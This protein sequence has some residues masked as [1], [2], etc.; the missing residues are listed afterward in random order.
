MIFKKTVSI[1]I[2]ISFSTGFLSAQSKLPQQRPS[3]MQQPSASSK[4]AP[5]DSYER[6]EYPDGDITEVTAVAGSG[7]LKVTGI[8]TKTTLL[9]VSKPKIG[10]RCELQINKTP[11]ASLIVKAAG[12]GSDSCIL[13]GEISVPPNI[14]FKGSFEK[15][16]LKV[17]GVKNVSELSMGSGD[18]ILDGINS[19][20]EVLIKKGSVTMERWASSATVTVQDEANVR[21]NFSSVPNIGSL[22][23]TARGGAVDINLPKNTTSGASGVPS[24]FLIFFKL[25]SGELSIKRF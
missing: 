8:T 25:D 5:V 13:D 20:V 12:L 21:C 24:N 18:L 23:I 22:T 3:S 19:Y 15:G 9:N 16:N 1:F 6:R 11:A 2:L 17:V 14:S 10:T 7:N 4:P